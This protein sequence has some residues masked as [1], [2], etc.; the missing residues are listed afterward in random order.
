M[1]RQLT[2]AKTR[3]NI[4]ATHL[5]PAVTLLDELNHTFGS[6]FVQQISMTTL[7]L[8]TAVQ[9]IILLISF[10]FTWGNGSLGVQNVKRNRDECIRLMENIHQVIYAIVHLHIK[11]EPTGSLHPAMLDHMGKFTESFIY[12]HILTAAEPI[13]TELYRRYTHILKHNKIRPGSNT[14]F[15]RMK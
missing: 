13:S 5:T 9:A 8:I 10:Y 1:P 11:S 2:D 14:S 4:I 7:T 12:L 3:L 15:G 6:T